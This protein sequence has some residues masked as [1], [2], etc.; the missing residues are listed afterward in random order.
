[1]KSTHR[2]TI[3]LVKLQAKACN[4]N[5]R[6]TLPWVFFTFIKLYKW[7]QM[8]QSI[9]Y[10][11]SCMR[12]SGLVAFPA[13]H[14]VLLCVYVYLKSNLSSSIWMKPYIIFRTSEDKNYVKI[15][16]PVYLKHFYLQKLLFLK[17]NPIYTAYRFE[18]R[19]IFQTYFSNVLT[20]IRCLERT[21]LKRKILLDS[22]F[23]QPGNKVSGQQ[24]LSLLNH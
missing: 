5:K 20:L 1:M 4:F 15:F 18:R 10:E 8:V 12:N 9:T 21:D 6:N 11:I 22:E 3:F 13:L 2:G 24:F 19:H 23:H 7:Y 14:Y 17:T 16:Q